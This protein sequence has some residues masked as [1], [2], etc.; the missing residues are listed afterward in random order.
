M[1]GRSIRVIR[2]IL[3]VAG[4]IV[5]AVIGLGV[6]VCLLAVM[7]NWRDSEPS[8]AAVRLA[9]L[10][11]DRPAVADDDNAFIYVMGFDVAPG[12]SPRQMG[13]KRVAW[14][15]AASEAAQLAAARD[16][17]ANPY[18]LRSGRDPRIQ[19]F[20]DACR[21]GNASCA[22]AFVAAEEVFEQWMASESWLLE[23]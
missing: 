20:L 19:E 11:R 12:E 4:W 14:M 7:I 2:G 9:S 6:A 17:L 5:G 22:A 13:L 15:R 23:R 21:P 18:D 8:A 3:K 1:V 10:H 16:P